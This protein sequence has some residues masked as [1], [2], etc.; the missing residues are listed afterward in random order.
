VKGN[1]TNSDHPGS[2]PLP[3]RAVQLELV[4][5]YFAYINDQFHSL[6]HPPSFRADVEQGKAPPVIVYAMIALSAR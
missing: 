5:L 6:F 4:D 2:V 3:E 1:N